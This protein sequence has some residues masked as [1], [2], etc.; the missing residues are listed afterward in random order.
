MRLFLIALQFLTRLPTPRGLRPS[1]EEM[2]RSARM[3]P[4]VGLVLGMILAL[5][6]LLLL[7]LPGFAAFFRGAFL[8][9][10]Q[11]VL[12]G[13]L[14]LDGLMDTADGLLSGRS[15]E[16]IIEI[17]KDSR[18]GANAVL[19]AFCLLL[20]KAG[21]LASLASPVQAMVPLFMPVLG[22]WVALRLA[23]QYSH[24]G[25]A[26][27]GR[28]VMHG[29]GRAELVRG[30][31]ICLAAAAAA[32][33]LPALAGGDPGAYGRVLFHLGLLWLA[34]AAAG[35]AVARA[36]VRKIGGLTG[37]VIGAATEL[38]ELAVAVLGAALTAVWGST[39]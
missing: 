19:A 39:A 22:R 4:L 25:A 33:A 24:A 31:S 5:E 3:Y 37:D 9:A 12:T 28:V 18:V 30:S 38:A 11:V 13:G 23:A 34:A 7:Q 10:T 15:R 14:H 17:M 20:L 32:A 26:G 2:G 27:L 36:A 8:A 1:E 16:R 6:H 21:A 35:A 29:A